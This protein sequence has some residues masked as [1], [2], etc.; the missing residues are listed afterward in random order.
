[1]PADIIDGRAIAQQVRQEVAR[2]V[3]ALR[4]QGVTPSLAAVLVGDNAA[5]VTYVRAKTQAAQEVEIYSETVRLPDTI[6]QDDL[7]TTINDLNRDPRFHG[8]IVQLPLPRHI[9]ERA[10]L[11]AVDP[12]KDVDGLHPLNMGRLLRGE[13]YLVP[14]TPA[15]VVEMLVRTGHQPDGR[16]VVVCG[17]SNLVGKPLAALLLQKREGANATVTVCHTGTPDLARFTRQADIL[18]AA[19]GSARAITADMVRAGAV[20]IDVG[21]NRVDDPTRKSGFRLVGDVDFAAV[22]EVAAAITPVPGGVGPMTVA[23]LLVN[24]VKAAEAQLE[25]GT[26]RL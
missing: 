24:T 12:A 13:P 10:I 7:L 19:M 23:M 1:M 16:H 25:G 9:D 26:T 8:V 17:R 6:S 22:S 20:V 11:N 5:S 3:A 2:R 4:A 18:V 14:G 21:T 15:G